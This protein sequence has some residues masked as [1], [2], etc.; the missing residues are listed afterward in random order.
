MI[1]PPS[2]SLSKFLIATTSSVVKYLTPQQREQEQQLSP[3]DFKN[4][5]GNC[6][7][8]GVN[9]TARKSLKHCTFDFSSLSKSTAAGEGKFRANKPVKRHISFSTISTFLIL[10]MPIFV[11]FTFMISV[12]F[13]LSRESIDVKVVDISQLLGDFAPSDRVVRLP[14]DFIP[15]LYELNLHVFLPYK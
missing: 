11:I 12:L 14:H 10:T 5:T 7:S 4:K 9:A 6:L 8:N 15:H 1:F 2:P 3:I 13:I